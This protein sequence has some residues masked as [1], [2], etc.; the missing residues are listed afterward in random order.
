MGNQQPRI[1]SVPDYSFS[2][3]V[4]AIELALSAGLDLD[5]WQQLAVMDALAEGDDGLWAAFEVAIL[6]ARQNGKGSIIEAIELAKL[7]LFGDR[8]IIHTAHEFKTAGEGYL[9]IKFLIENTPELHKKVRQYHG[10]H[11][12]EGITLKTGQRL[13]FLARS[14]GSGRGFSA[15]TLIYDEAY[16]LP[17]SSVAA[18]LPTL[19]ARPN[20]QVY[21]TSSAPLVGSD[22]LRDVRARGMHKEGTDWESLAF[23]EWSADPE[24]YEYGRDGRRVSLDLD[25]RRAWSDANPGLGRRLR[26]PF[27]K[28]ER[29]AMDD[30]EFS[31]ERLGIVDEPKFSAVITPEQYETTRD[32]KSQPLD[33]V[34]FA[35]DTN[36]DSSWSSISVAGARSDKRIHGEIADRRRG[37]GWVVD[38]MVEL[39][40]DWEPKKVIIDAMSPAASMIPQL[41]ERGIEVYVTNTVEYGRACVNILDMIENNRFRHTGQEQFKTSTEIASKRLIGEAGIWGW[42][43]KE[44]GD[45]SPL[46]SIT[47]AVFGYQLALA[48]PDEVVDK[49]VVIF[50][51]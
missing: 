21:Y 33:P 10:S 8:L 32:P 36:P 47:L 35:I 19:S 3:G 14:K 18:S 9:R 40:E 29:A 51:R 5:P 48:K 4:E 11:G 42:A 41:A 46:V 2:S 1:R 22:T 23:L 43:R 37:T 13:R 49:R 27:I 44:S 20:P 15:D 50:R 39:Y 31:R 24:G 17:S 12:E 30:E 45:I 7:F 28:K 38:R 34:V 26:E 25:D 16:E 6:V